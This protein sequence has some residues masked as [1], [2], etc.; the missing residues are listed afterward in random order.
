MRRKTLYYM[1]NLILP[2]V[3]ISCLTM[4]VFYLPATAGEKVTFTV[5]ILLALVVFLQLLVTNLLP[6]S[7]TSLPLFAKYLLFTIIIDVCSVLNTIVA[8]NWNWKTPRT[9]SMPRW[10]RTFFFKYLAKML[11]MERPGASDESEDELPVN[12]ANSTPSLRRV[13]QVGK[14]VLSDAHHPQCQYARMTLRQ[15]EEE[16]AAEQSTLSHLS[17]DF[18]KAVEAVRFISA[19]LKNE[20][21]YEEA[22]N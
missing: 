12:S 16:M 20:N 7:S 13:A 15:R 4:V 19:H 11:M 22:S 5:S 2:C 1:T 10:L 8:L 14:T 9:D 3:L 17:A 6:P 18:N 21:D